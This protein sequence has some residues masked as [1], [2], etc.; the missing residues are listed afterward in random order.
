MDADYLTQAQSFPTAET[1][2]IEHLLSACLK[3]ARSRALNSGQLVGHAA[4]CI[5]VIQEEDWHAPRAD[6]ISSLPYP[7][8]HALNRCCSRW[9]HW[10]TFNTSL[11]GLLAKGVN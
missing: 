4:S 5:V 10:Q 1:R 7:R 11:A 8:R 3:K 9:G 2:G 6:S